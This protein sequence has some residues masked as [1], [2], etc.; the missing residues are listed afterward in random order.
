MGH[1]V[2]HQTIGEVDSELREL[3]PH[4]ILN[5][6]TEKPER[7]LDG[8]HIQLLLH[9][10]PRLDLVRQV[11]WVSVQQT[12]LIPLELHLE[13]RDSRFTL[14]PIKQHH[15]QGYSVPVHLLVIRLGFVPDLE[16]LV[17]EQNSLVEEVGAF[18][19]LIPLVLIHASDQIFVR[20]SD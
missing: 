6:Q 3:S 16:H 4:R 20:V 15:S 13:L 2:L 12:V 7:D 17:L 9:L 19:A 11:L 8:D 10:V 14:V 1:Q 18:E 5:V